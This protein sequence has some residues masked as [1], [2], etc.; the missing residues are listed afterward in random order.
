MAK[1]IV[2]KAVVGMILGKGVTVQS[3]QPVFHKGL[4]I[5]AK[6]SGAV[7]RHEIHYA[8]KNIRK[9]QSRHGANPAWLQAAG[10]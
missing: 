8:P 4:K 9:Y 3:G 6:K 7:T 2:K 1:V 5:V 10:A